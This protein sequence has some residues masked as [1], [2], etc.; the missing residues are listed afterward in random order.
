M[1]WRST[2]RTFHTEGEALDGNLRQRTK[3]G[4]DRSFARN[5]SIPPVLNAGR[6]IAFGN[7]NSAAERECHFEQRQCVT[8]SR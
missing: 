2:D 5:H 7:E 8:E 6:S 4:I 3:P 1:E